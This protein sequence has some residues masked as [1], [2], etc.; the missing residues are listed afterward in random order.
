MNGIV[1]HWREGDDVLNPVSREY[2]WK[3]KLKKKGV[4]TE[5]DNLRKNSG[6]FE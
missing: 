6:N 3:R 4:L 2:K 1:M 5:L